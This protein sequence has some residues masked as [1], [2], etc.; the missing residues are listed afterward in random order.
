MTSELITIP[1]ELLGEIITHVPL[2]DLIKL[3]QSDKFIAQI[4]QNERLLS[5][6]IKEQ[7]GYTSKPKEFSWR[8]FAILLSSDKIRQVNI[9]HK[10]EIIGNI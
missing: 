7:T 5:L 9:L 6:V 4:C 1:K 2:V 10:G 3:C 8:Q